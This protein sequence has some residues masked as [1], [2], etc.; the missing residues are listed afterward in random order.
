MNKRAAVLGG[1]TG[2]LGIPLVKSLRSA[3]FEVRALGRADFDVLDPKALGEFLDDYKPNWVFN[4]VAYTAVDKAEDHPDE[5]AK[6]NKTLPGM[7][8]R[9]CAMRGAGL[10]HYS[11]DFVFDGT[12]TTPYTEEDGV[13]PTGVYGRSKLDG[14]REIMASGLDRWLILRTAWLFGSAKSNFVHK[15]IGLA[16]SRE[17]L[18]VV[19]DQLGS[20]TYTPDLADYSLALLKAKATGLFHVVNGGRASWCEL[21][22]EALTAAGLKCRIRPITTAEYPLKAT[23]PPYSVLDTGK[24]TKAT[25]VSPRPWLQ[26]LRDYVYR[27]LGAGGED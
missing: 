10:V 8:A 22:T 7:L 2:L 15:I 9:L 23:R 3:C 27:D 11:T 17:E 4:T 16:Q 1:H 26:A 24:F 6:L 14:E 25:G 5:A 13:N 18:S 12:K 20:P 19:H 21:A